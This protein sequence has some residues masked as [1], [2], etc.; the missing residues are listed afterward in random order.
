MYQTHVQ[1]LSCVVFQFITNSFTLYD[2][3]TILMKEGK[4][5]KK[6]IYTDQAFN[7][8]E[9]QTYIFFHKTMFNSKYLP[10][11]K[12]NNTPKEKIFSSKWCCSRCCSRFIGEKYFCKYEM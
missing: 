1:N 9:R 6:Y 12:S 3:Q 8:D 10:I 2:E 7:H 5:S 4:G 11:E